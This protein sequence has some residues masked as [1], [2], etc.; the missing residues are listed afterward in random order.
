MNSW[1]QTVERAATA[2]ATVAKSHFDSDLTVD[3]KSDKTDV[4]TVA[5]RSAQKRVIDE[6]R[7]QFTEEPIVAEEGE[8]QKHPSSTGTC[9]VVDP[10]D[11]TN[12]FV[13]SIP[14]WAT[15]VARLED[16]ECVAA[17]TVAPL[18]FGTF[19]ADERDTRRDGDSISVSDRSDPELCNVVPTLWWDYNDRDEY[20]GV[21]EGI[22][23][24][25]ADLKR[26]GSTQL[27]LAFLAAGQIDAV[28]TN[29]QGP[30]WDT[31][32]G[33]HLVRQAGGTVTDIY[34]D[35]WTHESKGLV[36]SNGEIHE[37]A[38]EA[39]DV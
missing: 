6:L 8:L 3:T 10:I 38:L 30:A 23:S 31:V 32:A 34:G 37:I 20:S 15:S 5:D 29:R 13:R 16:G 21:C 24:R 12:N 35:R 22:T 2:G 36:A 7:K 17:S 27:E 33:A 1:I 39:V 25:F 14:L 4:V 28:V 26:Y 11:G 19:V 9:F 18:G